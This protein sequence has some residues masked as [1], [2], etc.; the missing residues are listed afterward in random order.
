MYYFVKFHDDQ[1]DGVPGVDFRLQRQWTVHSQRL[2]ITIL[3]QTGDSASSAASLKSAARYKL[4]GEGSTI[5]D[6]CG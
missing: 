3:G 1:C 5:A 2:H 4:S 6:K